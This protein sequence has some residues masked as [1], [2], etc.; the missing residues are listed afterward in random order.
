MYIDD[1]KKKYYAIVK[2]PVSGANIHTPPARIH[3]QP[4]DR[5]NEP[6]ANKLTNK[7]NG[8]KYKSA[9]VLEGVILY[10]YMHKLSAILC[11]SYAMSFANFVILKD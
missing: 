2:S 9:F 11:T 7:I 10:V 8:R 1:E 5:I 6:T 4:F 3:S